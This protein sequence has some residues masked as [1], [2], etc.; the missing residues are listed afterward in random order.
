MFSFLKK[1]TLF[2][3]LYNEIA[4]NIMAGKIL[5]PDGNKF[6][7]HTAYNYQTGAFRFLFYEKEKGKIYLENINKQWA[8]KFVIFLMEKGYCKNSIA[9]TLARLKAVL[10]RLYNN[11][12]GT[13]NGHGIRAGNEVVTSVYTTLD[14]LK[15]LLEADF[16]ETPGLAKVRDVYVLQC[17]IGLRFADLAIVLKN[18]K[19]FIKDEAGKRFFEIKTQK[20]GEVVIIPLAKVVKEIL[21]KYDYDFGKLFSYQYYNREIKNMAEISGIKTEVVF[22]RTQGG[23]RT[24]QVRLKTELMSSHT[25]RRTFATNAFL[26]DLPIKNIM[27][28]TGH[29]TTSSFDRYVR[30]SNLDAAIKIANHP[31]FHIEMPVSLTLPEDVSL[32]NEHS[33]SLLQ[34]SK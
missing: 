25:A 26:S 15:L 9:V 27:L 8:E 6:S 32:S 4:A 11:G 23:L 12:I 28:I 30:C 24:D 5:T 17:F 21:V 29:K 19:Q 22:T 7:R 2:I 34:Q 31:F 20:T 3:P 10:R 33:I 13:Y 16:T 1:K 14:E 18:P